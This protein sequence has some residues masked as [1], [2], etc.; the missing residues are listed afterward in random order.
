MRRVRLLVLALVGLGPM[1][2]L[3]HAEGA[4]IEWETLNQ[5]VVKLRRSGQYDR[6]LALAQSVLHVAEQKVGPS[7]PDVATSLNNLAE[8]YRVQGYYAQAEPLYQRALAITENALGPDHPNVA[9]ILG[10]LAT[11]YYDQGHYAQAEMHYK[12]RAGDQG[13]SARPRPS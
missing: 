1:S 6:A 10:N 2:S 11:L 12:T 7:H 9:T 5:E 8:L 13:E 3:A 4:G